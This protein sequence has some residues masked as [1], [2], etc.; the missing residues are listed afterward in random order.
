LSKLRPS[1]PDAVI[2]C[3]AA[4]IKVIMVTVDHP[5]TSEAIAKPVNII[6]ADYT[7]IGRWAQQ[8]MK[9]EIPDCAEDE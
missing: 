2:K 6:P 1:V 9:P 7:K 3:Q 4:G 5:N 8:G